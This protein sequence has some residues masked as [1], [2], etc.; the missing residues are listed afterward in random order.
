MITLDGSYGEGGGALVRVALALSAFTGKPFRVHHI[1]AGKSD[2]GGLKPQHLEAIKALQKICGAQTNEIQLG[3]QELEF[4]P[5]KVKGGV[6]EIDIKTAGSITLLLQALLLPCLFAPRKVTLRV[7]GGTCG[8]WQASGDYLQ[9]LLLPHL[10]RFVEHIELRI[11][12]RGYYPQGGGQVELHITP[13][14]FRSSFP[15][16]NSFLQE[17]QHKCAKIFLMEAGKLEQI[18][19]V[20]NLSAELEEKQVGERIRKAAS[21]SLRKLAVP[22]NL[23]IEYVNSKS[24]GGECLL[25]AVFSTQG[26]VDFDNPVLL[27]GDALLEL[28]KRSEEVGKEAAEKLLKEIT[29]GAAV[30]GHLADQL[31]PFMALLPGSVLQTSVL[32]PHVLTNRY[33]VEHFLPVQFQSE[34]RTLSVRGI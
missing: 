27:G 17:L 30:D 24:V 28:G 4:T 3:S 20:I 8:K 33:V 9:N 26:Q 22:I 18:R 15:D 23:R 19:G 5:G 14:F 21:D 12:K 32:T 11:L 16:E 13:R 29:R 2:G 10:Q 31:V 6:Y 25:W 1:R 7:T 34:E